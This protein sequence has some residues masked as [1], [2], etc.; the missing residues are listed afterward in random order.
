[1]HTITWLFLGFMSMS[2]ETPKIMQ[3]RCWPA[4]VSAG[5]SAE[6]T[7]RSTIVGVAREEIGAVILEQVDAA[8]EVIAEL[9]EIPLQEGR[10]EH[11]HNLAGTF[12]I[13]GGNPDTYYYRLRFEHGGE[14][15]FSDIKELPITPF[16]LNIIDDPSIERAKDLV[17]HPEQAG[18]AEAD[19]ILVTFTPETS[20]QRIEEI[21]AR[22]NGKVLHLLSPASKVFIIY[23]PP[24]WSS[25][26][27]AK[28]IEAYRAYPEVAVAEANGVVRSN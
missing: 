28:A 13:H 5:E 11:F 7:F 17:D 2:Q 24:P 16:P 18:T 20:D 23:V 27:L 8:G 3:L 19:V 12:T 1:M 21:V 22:E 25:E 26:K 10:R 14:T 4:A 9:G 15:Y 6:I